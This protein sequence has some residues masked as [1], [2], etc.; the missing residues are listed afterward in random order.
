M[1]YF[2]NKECA[3]EYAVFLDAKDNLCGFFR[4]AYKNSLALPDN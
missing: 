1:G 2:P 4:W 3:K